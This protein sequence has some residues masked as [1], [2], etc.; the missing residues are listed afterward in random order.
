M[1]LPIA[2]TTAMLLCGVAPALAD[3]PVDDAAQLTQRSQ[4]AS[5]TVKLVPVTTQ[6]QDANSGVKCAVTTGKKAT[7]T[8]PTVQ[9]SAVWAHRPASASQ[10]YRST[11]QR[12]ETAENRP[13]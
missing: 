6:R 9:P 11:P 1:K 4:T 8:N 3:I 12:A 13:F 7:I 5:T 10:P 2:I